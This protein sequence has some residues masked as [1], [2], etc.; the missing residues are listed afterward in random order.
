MIGRQVACAR[1]VREQ[2]HQRFRGLETPDCPFA[3]LP[4]A[5][6][7]QHG[8][9]LNFHP[10]SKTGAGQGSKALVRLLS[11]FR[12]PLSS[13]VQRLA[14]LWISASLQIS[15]PGTGGRDPRVA[16]ARRRECDETNVAAGIKVVADESYARGRQ[17][18]AA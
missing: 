3:N 12:A 8:L 5:K 17:P 7:G 10:V 11:M 2:L 6:P 4:E 13:S 14:T 16:A 9:D 18:L 1:P 15:S